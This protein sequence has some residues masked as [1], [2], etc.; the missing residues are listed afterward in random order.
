MSR[1]PFEFFNDIRHKRTPIGVT[2]SRLCHDRHG[3]SA[4]FKGYW[5]GA[6]RNRFDSHLTVALS[7]TYRPD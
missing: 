4:S 7:T 6:M 5:E 3:E 2:P 1:Y